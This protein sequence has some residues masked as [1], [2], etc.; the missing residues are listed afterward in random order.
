MMDA[1]LNAAELQ[2]PSSRFT[3]W[4]IATIVVI[5]AL[6]IICVAALVTHGSSIVSLTA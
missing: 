1:V 2:K 5:I 4:I 6:A 3:G